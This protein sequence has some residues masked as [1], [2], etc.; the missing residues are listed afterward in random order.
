M[1][2]YTTDRLVHI[3]ARIGSLKEAA[4]HH[5]ERGYSWP[6]DGRR[7]AQAWIREALPWMEELH[8]GTSK[9]LFEQLAQDLEHLDIQTVLG[10]A[11]QI[12]T[13]LQ[14]E[15]QK[16]TFLVLDIE[17]ER[18]YSN[19]LLAGEK[20][21]ENWPKANAELIE[22]GNCFALNRYT[23]CVCHLMRSLE[24]ALKSIE[25]ELRITPPPPGPGNTWGSII[26]RIEVKK[27]RRGS[28]NPSA[29]WAANA[30]F[31]DNCLTFFCAIKSACRDKTF[32]VEATYDKAGA[33]HLFDCTVAVLSKI[34][35]QL[36]EIK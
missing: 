32:H 7:K 2:Q 36:G 15:L 28:T 10:K 21:K 3:M 19:Q 16:R 35:E 23:G 27:G 12:Q 31:Y 5:R 4:V 14:D 6:N 8:L 24:Y 22:A 26:Q 11:N 13:V 20:F 17:T 30:N 1:H 29:E 9:L 33:Q 34:S 25:A 18:F